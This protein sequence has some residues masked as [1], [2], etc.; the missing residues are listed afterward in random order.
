MNWYCIYYFF[1]VISLVLARSKPRSNS[2]TKSSAGHGGG[3]FPIENFMPQHPMIE[4]HAGPTHF[5]SGGL[6]NFF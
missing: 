3:S 6:G 1:S 4:S 2:K 5:I